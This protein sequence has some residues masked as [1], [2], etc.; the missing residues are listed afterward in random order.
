MGEALHPKPTPQ[1]LLVCGPL[2]VFVA[3][4]FGPVR[5]A[6]MDMRWQW[7]LLVSISVGHYKVPCPKRCSKCIAW[8][9]HTVWLQAS[10]SSSFAASLLL[11]IKA[12]VFAESHWKIGFVGEV[13]IASVRGRKYENCT[14]L[15]TMFLQVSVL[16]VLR[17]VV[18]DGTPK[19]K[20]LFWRRDRKDICLDQYWGHFVCCK[21]NGKKSCFMPDDSIDCL[22]VLVSLHCSI[23][24]TIP[25]DTGF[26]SILATKVVDPCWWEIEAYD[27][28]LI[29][30]S[31]YSKYRDI[32]G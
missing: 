24:F 16:P 29:E 14:M 12:L 32:I 3:F 19:K 13:S 4:V 5:F 9:F 15:L 10:Q 6:F 18:T 28:F 2:A 1:K 30:Q 25:S 31:S 26:K 23:L 11:W 20:Q 7:R 27:L 21:A 22:S 17:V 8:L